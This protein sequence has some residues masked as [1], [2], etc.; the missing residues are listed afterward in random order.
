MT[1]WIC[2][3]NRYQQSFLS[4]ALFTMLKSMGLR[5]EKNSMIIWWIDITYVTQQ[6]KTTT[7]NQTNG[8]NVLLVKCKVWCFTIATVVMVVLLSSIYYSWM[9]FLAFG[10]SVFVCILQLHRNASKSPLTPTNRIH[11]RNF[12]FAIYK[13]LSSFVFWNALQ[14]PLYVVLNTQHAHLVAAFT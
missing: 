10:F 8:L 3:T 13:F 4:F 2:E 12:S 1:Y 11:D 14:L 5:T 9:L 7:H 6:K